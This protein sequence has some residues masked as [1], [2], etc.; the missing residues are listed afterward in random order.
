MKRLSLLL[1]LILAS[2]CGTTGTPGQTQSVSAEPDGALSIRILP[3]PIVAQ[4]IADRTYEF[5]FDVVV[6][7]T[8]SE[9]ATIDRVSVD[10]YALGGN[11]RVYR[12]SYDAAKIQALGYSTAIP[13]DGEVRY[14]FAPRRDVPDDRLFGGV[15][16]D[17]KVEG[18]RA[19]SG[20]AMTS[21]T[22]VTVTR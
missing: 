16:A 3:N 2:A 6:R 7:A 12:E 14:H 4:H 19:G 5:P 18:R 22:T 15:A 9:G 11:L 17:L 1:L 20:G 8:G 10:V 21:T 13:R